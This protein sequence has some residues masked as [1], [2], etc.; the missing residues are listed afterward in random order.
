MTRR[1]WTTTRRSARERAGELTTALP[2]VRLPLSG[3]EVS[4]LAA[5]DSCRGD[6]S[7]AA[8][9]L[10]CTAVLF[11]LLWRRIWRRGGRGTAAAQP[12]RGPW[13]PTPDLDE[14]SDGR[15]LP[16]RLAW[17]VLEQ[18]RPCSRWHG[19]TT[20]GG[21]STTNGNDGLKAA[22]Q[23]EASTLRMLPFSAPIF[24]SPARPRGGWARRHALSACELRDPR[25]L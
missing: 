14:V 6:W 22:R 20:G 16:R 5:C 17:R 23:L 24:P 1:R 25:Y 3:D 10:A 2:P 15:Q 13:R 19:S 4:L 18:R 21:G 8:E 12:G 9:E 11:L 7:D